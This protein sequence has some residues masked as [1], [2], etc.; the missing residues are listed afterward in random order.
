[1]KKSLIF[2]K[3]ANSPKTSSDFNESYHEIKY[4]REPYCR[5]FKVLSTK[6]WNFVFLAEERWCSF[7]PFCFI[8][9]RDDYIEPMALEIGR[10]L[11]R[12]EGKSF[13]VVFK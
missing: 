7:V 8:F 13:R 12:M 11:V 5:G 10:E 3:E 1:M 9:T 2:E 6:L 4:I